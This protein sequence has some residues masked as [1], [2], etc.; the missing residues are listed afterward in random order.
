MR[1]Y[2][3]EIRRIA[4]ARG[5]QKLYHFTPLENVASI[6]QNGL[7][8]QNLLQAHGIAFT[9]PDQLRLDNCLD[10]I[11]LSIHSFNKALLVKKGAELGGDWPILEIDASVLW[12]HRCR[13]CWTNAASSEIANHRGFL[14]GEWGLR[15]MFEDA[16]VS[17]SDPRSRR[18]VYG[19]SDNQPTDNQAEVL[20][21]D[22]IDSDLVIDFTVKSQRVKAR[23]EA[24][25][26]SVGEHR[27]VVVNEAVFL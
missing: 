11:S 13:F 19:R 3:R 20:V 17:L 27:P 14:G 22:P 18:E 7:A 2:R 5:I 23:L 24:V 16:P 6:L 4:T 12:T 1:D 10:A 9:A 26:A 21:F 25:M 8:S 15:R